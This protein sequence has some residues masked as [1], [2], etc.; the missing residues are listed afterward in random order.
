MRVRGCGK[1]TQSVILY[2]N[3]TLSLNLLGDT[4]SRQTV[5]SPKRKAKPIRTLT[6]M[7]IRYHYQIGVDSKDQNAAL[8]SHVL[9]QVMLT[10][11]N[12]GNKDVI[13]DVIVISP[14]IHSMLFMTDTAVNV[15]LY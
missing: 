14:C 9:T 7:D 1:M 11:E 8:P 3:N 5:A 10:I 2:I 12:D 6:S 15:V 4:S 13:Y